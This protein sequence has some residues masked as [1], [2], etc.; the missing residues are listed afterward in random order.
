[1]KEYIFKAT[2]LLPVDAATAWAFFSSAKNLSRITPPELDFKI[3]SGAAD[4]D[5]F[6]G[7]CIDYTVKPLFGIK[8]HWQTMIMQVNKPF[9][10]MDRQLKGPY[11]KWEHTHTFTEQNGIT[12]MHDE[13]RYAMPLGIL[14]Q[15]THALIVRKKI[16]EIFTY[17]KKILNE[18]F[19]NHGNIHH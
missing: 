6:E 14:G 10:F 16:E 8:V 1:M 11:K 15:L 7:M 19:T 5:I 12:S 9:Q 17:R 13:V 3:L 2:Q 4:G 18:I